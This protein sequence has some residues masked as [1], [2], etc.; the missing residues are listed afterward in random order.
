[1]GSATAYPVRAPE[2]ILTYQGVDITADVS[3]MV[4]SITY[5]DHL[6]ALSGEIEIEVE[7]HDQRWQGPWYPGLGDQVNLMMGYRGEPMLPCGDFEI[8]Q[9]ELSG[10]P[11]AFTMRGLAAFVTPA[12]RTA[13][14]AG[15]EGQSL[16][17]IAKT[18]AA[19]Y[20][21]S[22]VS[23]PG[24]ADLKFNRVTQN[25]ETDLGFLKRLAA[26]H[27]FEFTV[28]GSSLVFYARSALE[29]A[30]AVKTVT[31]AD[32]LRF[33][34]NNRTRH[35]YKSAL[36]SYQDPTTKTLIAQTANPAATMPTGDTL[37]RVV[38]CE[39]GQQAALKAAAA[40][41]ANNLRF[42]EGALRT[43]GSTAL[44]AGNNVTL[45]GFGN[46][47][48]VYLIRSAR[49]HMAREVGYITDVEVRR[50]Q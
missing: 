3:R 27:D 35:I 42:V 9:L 10:P 32:T 28:R 49:H 40:L 22:V 44:S 5:I 25:G 17:A 47:D 48:G 8:D 2:W 45:S 29:S 20:G 36:V 4:V 38:R 46:L 41:H 12:M 24:A 15:Y 37:K 33:G 34:F 30:A 19:K 26:E 7:D 13:N 11:D 31:R 21:Y 23:A 50:V 43:P 1:M 6:D 14:S 18:I 16:L 39:N